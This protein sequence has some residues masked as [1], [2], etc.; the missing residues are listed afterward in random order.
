MTAMLLTNINLD[1]VKLLDQLRLKRLRSFFA[2]SL[3][4]CAIRRDRDQTLIVHCLEASIIDAVLSDLEELCDYAWLIL[5]VEA[6]AL[7]FAQE[8]I[9][10]TKIFAVHQKSIG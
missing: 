1:D 6:I 7:Y 5:G 10:R 2:Q 8:E 3:L 9:C 4:H